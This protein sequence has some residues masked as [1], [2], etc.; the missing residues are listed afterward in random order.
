MARYAPPIIRNGSR[1]YSDAGNPASGVGLDGD[2]YLNL[3]NGAVWEKAGGTW[4]DTGSVM[5]GADGADGAD[6]LDGANGTDGADGIDG[7]TIGRQTIWMPS[8]ALIPAST[9]GP[10]SQDIE[11]TTNLIN[12]KPLRFSGSVRQNAHFNIGMPKGWDEG[13]LF[14]DVLWMTAATDADSAV[15]GLEARA[16]G[17]G[18]DLNGAWGTAVTVTDAAQSSADKLMI[19]PISAGIT[20]GN[21][22]AENDLVFFRF[23]RDPAD[24]GDTIAETVDVVGIR[25]RYVIDAANDD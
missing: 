6:G 18:D 16:V 22:P 24:A 19:T 1:W 7:N 3:T 15:F 21:T 9:D 4:V 8:P 10:E 20:P 12:Y 5:K 13:A 25:P 2:H 14:F 11:T 23:F 17:D